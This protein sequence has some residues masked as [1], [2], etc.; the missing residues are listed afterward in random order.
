MQRCLIFLDRVVAIKVKGVVFR[1]QLVSSPGVGERG[2]ELRISFRPQGLICSLLP[3]AGLGIS[4]LIAMNS[5]QSLGGA[6]ILL[7]CVVSATEKK[8]GGRSWRFRSLQPGDAA[9]IQM[10]SAGIRITR[11]RIRAG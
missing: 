2:F 1:T 3:I 4:I 10:E 8:V 5:R 9:R 6:V 11:C 7:Q